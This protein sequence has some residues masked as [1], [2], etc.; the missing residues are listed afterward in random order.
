M[1][2]EARPGMDIS[3]YLSPLA[4][5]LIAALGVAVGI[6]LGGPTAVLWFAFALLSGAVLLFWESLRLVLDPTAAGDVDDE[7]EDGVPVALEARK[8]A[9]LRALKDID[10]ERSIGRLGEED[11]KALSERYR[12][13]AKT[14]M[15]ALDEGMHDWMVT[16][17]ALLREA[18]KADS[19]EAVPPPP[20]EDPK[21][22][23][24]TTRNDPD[25]AFCKRCGTRLREEIAD[26]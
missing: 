7:D 12:D 25:A 24:C 9:A 6:F 20:P 21:C 10:Y 14:A 15:R 22:A 26:A 1:S 23:K 16:A 11:H 5:V 8:R 18:E 4:A 2:D 19:E 13:E 17:E 3:R